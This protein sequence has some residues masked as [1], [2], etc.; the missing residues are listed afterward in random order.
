MSQVSTNGMIWS[1][2][3]SSLKVAISVVTGSSKK[4]DGYP[5]YNF[6]VVIDD[7]DMQISHV[8]RGDDHIANTPKQLMVYEALGWEAPE[9]GHMTLIINSE[10]GKKLSKRD[11]NTLQFIEDYRK[12]GYLPEAVFNFIAL[13][14]WNPGGEDEIFSRRTHQAL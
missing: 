14:G 1:K 11:T 7:H 12:K 10:T 4:K 3:I 2:A 6:A 8:I 9:F 5:T 13:L